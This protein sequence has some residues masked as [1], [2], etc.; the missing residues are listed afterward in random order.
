MSISDT[1]MMIYNDWGVSES[2][3]PKN[4]PKKQ[5][6]QPNAYMNKFPAEFL[7]KNKVHFK[8]RAPL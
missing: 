7:H 2:Y 8:I 4:R 5:E 6:H 1:K 3:L